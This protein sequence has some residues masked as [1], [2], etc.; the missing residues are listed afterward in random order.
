M[1]NIYQPSLGKEELAAIKDVFKSNWLGKGKLTAEFEQRFGEHLG[2]N[3]EHLLS[4]NCCSEGLFASMDIFNIG[5]GDEVILP[6]CSFVGAAN[7]IKH[8][9]ADLLFD[10]FT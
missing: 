5:T 1:I 6:T 8:C 7:A 10:Y 4:T 2:V 3:S 9:G